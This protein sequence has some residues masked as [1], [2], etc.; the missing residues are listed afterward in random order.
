MKEILGHEMVS[1]SGCNSMAT[2]YA[3][4]SLVSESYGEEG[5]QSASPYHGEYESEL[6]FNGDVSTKNKSSSRTT[7]TPESTSL[8]S[9]QKGLGSQTE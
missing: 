9:R 7:V 1:K 4:E 3:S 8:A 2:S 6:V 5:D